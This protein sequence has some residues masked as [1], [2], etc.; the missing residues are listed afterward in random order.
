MQCFPTLFRE[1]SLTCY[2]K[3]TFFVIYS[4]KIELSRCSTRVFC[5]LI[6]YKFRIHPIFITS[7][8]PL[9]RFKKFSLVNTFTCDDDT[10]INLSIRSLQ[11]FAF[12]HLKIISVT[13]L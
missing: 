12:L 11:L 1:Q 10:V 2:N 3:L 5:F 6:F 13:S 4:Q 9:T 7:N 8:I